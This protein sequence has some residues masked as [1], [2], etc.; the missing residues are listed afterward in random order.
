MIVNYSNKDSYT[1][2]SILLGD[3]ENGAEHGEEAD[4]ALGA[5]LQLK[6]QHRKRGI[7]SAMRTQYLIRT[8]AIDLFEI[9]YPRLELMTGRLILCWR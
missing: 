4:E 9:L 5:L 8:R 1:P 3:C 6:Q 7:L 2:V